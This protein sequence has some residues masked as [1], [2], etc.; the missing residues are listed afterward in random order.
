VARND[1]VGIRLTQATLR[2]LKQFV[3]EPR[4]ERSGA[5]II[6]ETRMFSGTLY[7]MLR[8]LE[9]A[10][11]LTASWE[12]VDP[13]EAGRPR[14]RFYRITALGQRLTCEALNE[15]GVPSGQTAAGGFAWNS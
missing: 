14:Q 6:R 8:R 2:V 11:W 13:K 9:R 7:P 3:D 4:K 1:E 12:T 10:G 15:I 5:E